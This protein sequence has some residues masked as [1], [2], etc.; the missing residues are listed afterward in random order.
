MI[1]QFTKMHGAGN[2]FV[3]A[4]DRAGKLDVTPGLARR[5]LDRRFGVGADQ[6]LVIRN[7]D[8]ADFEMRI[9]NPDG[10]EVEMCGNGVRCAAIYAKSRGIVKKDNMSVKTLA[11][12]IRPAIV[13]DLVRVDMGIPEF[14]GPKIPVDL[15]GEVLDH[16]IEVGG[17]EFSINCVSMGNPHCV[18]YTDDV[19]NAPVE[20]VGPMIERHALFPKRVNVEFI[21][22][23]SRN[24]IKMRV[25]ERGTGETLACGT[26]ATAAAVVSARKGL[27]GREVTV[28]LRGGDLRINWLESGRVAM[29]GPAVEVY[30]GEINID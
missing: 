9:Y 19:E 4:D 14:D 16:P 17:R 30:R 20:S 10:S 23:L 29:T 24:E 15:D 27:T 6:L 3:M 7:T 11:G 2:D 1:I 25:W 13:G 26:G 12:I 5:I 18:I 22:V 8:E 21:T 28:H